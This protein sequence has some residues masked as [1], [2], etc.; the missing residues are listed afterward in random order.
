MV[1]C[2]TLAATRSTV[3][4]ALAVVSLDLAA[5]SRGSVGGEPKRVVRCLPKGQVCVGSRSEVLQNG[6]RGSAL[7]AALVC[8]ERTLTFPSEQ[9]RK[10]LAEG[11]YVAVFRQSDTNLQ[12]NVDVQ[13]GLIVEIVEYKMASYP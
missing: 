3:L 13:D 1:C 12:F 11:R 2:Q 8:D 9:M 7:L 10:C 5:C 6:D 4:A